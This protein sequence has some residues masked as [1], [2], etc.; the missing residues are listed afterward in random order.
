[1]NAVS[2]DPEDG[3]PFQGQGAADGQ[4]ILQPLGRAVAAM[5]EQ[6]MIAHADAHVDGEYPEH[7]EAEEGFPG[8]HEES[9]YGEH[10]K[11]HHKA[12]GHPVA[13]I[14]LSVAAKNRHV[15]VLFRGPRL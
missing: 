1:M 7:D 6:A 5:G 12:G 8:K 9:D 4:E 2:S 15:T 13:L 10:M 11:G 3:S 14:G